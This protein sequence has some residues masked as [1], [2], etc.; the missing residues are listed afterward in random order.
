MR[1]KNLA[2]TFALITTSVA[3]AQTAGV[4]TLNANQTSAQ[5]SM[6]PVLTWSTTPAAQSCVASGG[7]SGSKAA[8]GTQTLTTINASTNYTLTCTWGDGTAALSWTPPTTNNDGS[9][10]VD[11]AG[12]RV[13]YGT[14]PGALT[15]LVI[16]NDTRTS[17]TVQSLTP[18]TWYFVVRA[19][20][21]K[22]VESVD[23]NSAQKIVTG[24]SAS[25]T[26]PITIAQ[27]TLKTAATQ[28]YDVRYGTRLGR[29][30][31]TIAL[32]KPCSSSFKVGTDYYQVTRSD[33]SLTRSP[34]SQALV[35]RCASG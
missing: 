18:G 14:S 31:G 2:I 9:A 3:H 15:Q 30:V 25:S 11:L 32:G 8:S 28:V 5:T 10:L 6:T 16:I 13:A 20:N 17:Y 1:A 26:V 33:V 29:Q 19:I 35:A 4:V 7:W 24:G 12:F 27:A 23:S 21:T 22:Q 34:R